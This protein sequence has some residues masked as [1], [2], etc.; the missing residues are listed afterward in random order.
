MITDQQIELNS[1]F[2]L[3]IKVIHDKDDLAFNTWLWDQL[4]HQSKLHTRNHVVTLINECLDSSGSRVLCSVTEFLSW[5]ALIEGTT[6]E[7]TLWFVLF[8]TW[9][10][11]ITMNKSVI[12]I[13]SMFG[14]DFS[15]Y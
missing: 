13:K 10:D 14:V 11:K 1:Q 8:G 15:N 7:E 2:D 12:K 6:H 9:D 5:I 4:V 3:H